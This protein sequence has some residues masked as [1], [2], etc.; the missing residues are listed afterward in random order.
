MRLLR[1]LGRGGD[2]GANR[3]HR[4][5]RDHDLG[6]VEEALD[7][8]QLLDALGN[9]GIDALLADGQRLADGE[10]DLEPLLERVGALGGEQLV[11]LGRRRQAELAA[12]LRVATESQKK[13][14]KRQQ[15]NTAGRRGI[16][17]GN[18]S[19]SEEL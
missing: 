8:L 17:H 6:G 15:E 7:A 12:A 19:L 4:L 13:N 10:D 11:R 18:Q 5:V 14:H 9:D 2:A 16:A 1:L 3:P